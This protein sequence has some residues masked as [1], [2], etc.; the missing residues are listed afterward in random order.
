M[1]TTKRTEELRET[2][3]NLGADAITLPRYLTDSI[4]IQG[5]IA[6]KVLGN[7]ELNLITDGGISLHRT[8]GRRLSPCSQSQERL[9]AARE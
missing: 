8:F 2:Y 3:S 5:A 9:T 4:P 6:I 1:S 7:G